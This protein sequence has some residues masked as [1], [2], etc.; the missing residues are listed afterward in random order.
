MLP[1]QSNLDMLRSLREFALSMPVFIPS[2][3]ID[4]R[5]VVSGL[6]AAAAPTG[7]VPSLRLSQPAPHTAAEP[8]GQSCPSGAAGS[9]GD[10]RGIAAAAAHTGQGPANSAGA[11]YIPLP[12]PRTGDEVPELAEVLSQLPGRLQGQATTQASFLVAGDLRAT[13]ATGHV[14]NRPRRERARPGSPPPAPPWLGTTPSWPAR[15]G[16]L[17]ISC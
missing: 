8:I 13:H 6:G 3:L 7:R 1:G 12:V 10:G 17:A 16:S 15:A 9:G 14:A 11:G 5:H 2:A 4:A